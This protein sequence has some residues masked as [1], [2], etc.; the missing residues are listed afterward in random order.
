MWTA[1]AH[2]DCGAIGIAYCKERRS[3]KLLSMS[4]RWKIQKKVYPRG[5]QREEK[6]RT[7][8]RRVVPAAIRLDKVG[9]PLSS[10]QRERDWCGKQ[11]VQQLGIAI[12][13]STISLRLR[14]QRLHKR[15]DDVEHALSRL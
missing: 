13:E 1:V 12:L 2:T 4:D 14:Q 5:S 15:L 8:Q 10:R 6:A 9:E 3:S 7:L 11:R